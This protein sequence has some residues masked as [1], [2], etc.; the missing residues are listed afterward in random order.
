MPTSVKGNQK[1][2]VIPPGILDNVRPH[3]LSLFVGFQCR[4]LPTDRLPIYLDLR[5]RLVV[6]QGEQSADF[7]K[8]FVCN[9]NPEVVMKG[10]EES[11]LG[12]GTLRK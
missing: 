10:A 8:A 9:L 12:R 1:A 7:V 5:H 11:G 2:V 4:N 3:P 6:K